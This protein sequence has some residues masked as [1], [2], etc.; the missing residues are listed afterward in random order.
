MKITGKV[1]IDTFG[2]GTKSEHKSA[3]L[4]SDDIN[5]KLRMKGGN[6]FEIDSQFIELENKIITISGDNISNSIFMVNKIEN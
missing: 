3:F 1:Y 6:P 4:K 5:Y 2:K